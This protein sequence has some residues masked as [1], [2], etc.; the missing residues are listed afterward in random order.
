MV[1]NNM[2]YYNLYLDSPV[3]YYKLDHIK[4]LA[5]KE[6]LPLSSKLIKHIEDLQIKFIEFGIDFD[7]SIDNL[8]ICV[9]HI[10]FHP[11]SKFN[12]PLVNLP[13]N[14][15]TLILGNGYWK[16]MEYL[17]CSLLFL[18]YHKFLTSFREKYNNG[19]TLDDVMNTSLPNLLYISIPNHLCV[20]LEF[21]SNIYKN[22]IMKVSSEPF[23]TFL[24]FIKEKYFL[25][26]FMVYG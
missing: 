7:Q 4:I 20:A 16:T 15:K 9:E 18:G 8:P 3:Y 1:S 25:D 22:K 17:P 6:N 5:I 19:L 14:L 23:W 13:I 11:D 10:F 12:K 21:T 2:L 24:N 26:Y